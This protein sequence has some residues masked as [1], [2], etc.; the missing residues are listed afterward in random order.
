MND[1]WVSGMGKKIKR[2]GYELDAKGIKSLQDYEIKSILRGADDLI[3]SAGRSM[4]AKILA[5]SKDKKLL[6]L[7]L[8]QSPVY[9]DFKGVSQ[10]D[11]VAKIDWMILNDYLDIEYDY[12]MPLLVFTEKGWEIE[13]E[14]FANELLEQIME[15][16]ENRSYEFVETLKDRNRGMIFLLLDKIGETGNKEFITILKAWQMIDYKKVKV[17]IQEV[18]DVLKKAE[19]PPAVHHDQDVDVL[20]FSANKKWLAIPAKTRR[21][22]ERN[23]WCVSCLDVVQIVH[24]V[25][26]ESPPGIVLEGKCKKCGHEVTRFIEQE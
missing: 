4:L 14:T 3:M 16:S 8:D 26:K 18:I 21:E 1:R 19:E 15:A 25:I 22:L 6:E 23:V 20:S 11:I 24:Y 10:K 2:V 9:G 17:K 12:K 5:G 7:G 13:R